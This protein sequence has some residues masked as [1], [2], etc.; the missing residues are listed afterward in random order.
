VNNHGGFGRWAFVEVRDPWDAK[1]ELLAALA[2]V[3]DNGV[4][5]MAGGR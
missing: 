3:A 1:A 2:A 5:V 4:G